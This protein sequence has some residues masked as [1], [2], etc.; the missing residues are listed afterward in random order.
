[1]AEASSP[2]SSPP[3]SIINVQLGSPAAS[4]DSKSI[5]VGRQ[6]LV[7]ETV[8]ASTPRVTQPA[9]NP[10]GYNQ[11]DSSTTPGSEGNGQ[12][13]V[14]K[15][16]A[17]IASKPARAKKPRRALPVTKKSA[18]DKKWEAPLVYTDSK[19]P[20][21]KAD[22]RAILLLPGAWDVLTEGEKQEILAK[23]PD[24]TH[25]QDT[26]TPDSR[27]NTVSL[28]NDDNFRYDCAR[29]CENIYLGRHDEEWLYQ[30]WV[31]HEKHRRGDFDEFLRE[32][33]EQDWE[34]QLPG[35]SKPEGTDSDH[36]SETATEQPRKKGR[37]KR[38]QAASETEDRETPPAKR[39]SRPSS[40]G[41]QPAAEGGSPQPQGTRN[42]LDTEEQSHS[43]EE[44]LLTPA[45]SQKSSKSA[46]SR[47]RS[48]SNPTSTSRQ[49]EGEMSIYAAQPD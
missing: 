19:S 35:E 12:S 38:S 18:K 45:T 48:F 42:G 20:L 24:E 4:P 1:M 2:I 13:G 25:I 11:E 31:A 17:N 34:T 8:E 7:S 43:A 3:R 27:P 30:A 44:E 5:A 23:F 39:R 15:R 32:R 33:F 41:S 49:N 29:Y 46:G 16:K 26:G 37:G 28:R 40:V 21:A 10:N 14:Q 47:Q 22:L 6:E 36:G 9:T